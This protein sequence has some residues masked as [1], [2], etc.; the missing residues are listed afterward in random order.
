MDVHQ[1]D[2]N[3]TAALIDDSQKE[4]TNSEIID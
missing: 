4:K 3:L 1:N 2:E